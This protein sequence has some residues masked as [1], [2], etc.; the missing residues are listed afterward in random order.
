[1]LV[2]A[3]IITQ[4]KYFGIAALFLAFIRIPGFIALVKSKLA[5]RWRAL[6]VDLSSTLPQASETSET[7]MPLGAAS[8]QTEG[9][10]LTQRDPKKWLL[11]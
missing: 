11:H 7:E 6:S 2:L 8:R 3:M 4:N 9:N 5:R 10:L 1:M